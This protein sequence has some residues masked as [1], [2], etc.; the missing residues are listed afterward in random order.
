MK[1]FLGF[2]IIVALS[3][4]ASTGEQKDEN[5]NTK[6]GAG[7]GAAVGAV[8]GS[9]VSGDKKKGAV[10]GGVLGGIAG[11]AYGKKLDEQAK[12][13]EEVAETK[14]TDQGII[15]KL[16]GDI[17]F[18]T[19]K[20]EVRPEAKQRLQ[21]MADILKKYP[22]NQITVIGHTDSTGPEPVNEELSKERAQE[23]KQIL[24]S[25]GVPIESVNT[26]GVASSDPIASNQT[27]QGRAANR[28]VELAITMDETESSRQAE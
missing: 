14:R 19:G 16:K 6:K 22:E 3:G 20:S 4:C 23:V 12:E 26:M 10:I 8:A 15:T 17:T 13:L 28:R 27:K 11:G 2:A 5:I 9:I 7:I 24:V 25:N 18:K 21:R 1:N